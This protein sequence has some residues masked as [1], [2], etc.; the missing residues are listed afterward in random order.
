MQREVGVPT[1]VTIDRPDIIAMIEEATG[2]LTAGNKTDAVALAMRC[3]LDQHAWRG[4]L[5]GAHPGSVRM[6]PDV[7]LTAP[8]LDVEPDAATGREAAR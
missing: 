5:F 2:A 3:L 6:R 7:G 1:V 4:P 8:A